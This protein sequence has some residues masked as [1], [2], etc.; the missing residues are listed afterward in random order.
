[1]FDTFEKEA[2]TVT[3]PRDALTFSAW[4]KATSGTFLRADKP[5]ID[6]AS[7]DYLGSSASSRAVRAAQE[8]LQDSGFGS[9]IGR[10]WI[11]SSPATISCEENLAKHWGVAGAILFPGINQAVFSLVLAL[12]H[13]QDLFIV[14]ETTSG[15]VLDVAALIGCTTIKYRAGEYSKLVL[16]TKHYRRKFLFVDAVEPNGQLSDLAL[17]AKAASELGTVLFVDDSL[18]FGIRTHAAWFKTLDLVSQAGVVFCANFSRRFGIQGAGVGGSR[19]AVK[20]ISN[21]SRA[22]TGE[23]AFSGPYAAALNTIITAGFS[24][25]EL[26][27]LDKRAEEFR[28]SLITKKIIPQ[29]PGAS[30]P[31]VS[32]PTK[33]I[34]VLHQLWSGLLERGVLADRF[35]SLDPTMPG[36]YVRIFIRTAHTPAEREIALQAVIDVS[37]LTV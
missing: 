26:V 30:A 8:E 31:I 5:A 32:I 24:E 36:G 15:P 14:P 4:T 22:L 3:T 12:S 13:E 37:K 10:R 23:P 33:D 9:P 20:L 35:V 28:L 16:P 2:E 11:G 27:Q 25:L 19:A 6:F 18:G 29:L 7:W 34:R 1:M 21:R 17:A